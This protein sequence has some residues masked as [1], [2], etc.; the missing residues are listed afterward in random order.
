M[1]IHTFSDDSFFTAASLDILSRYEVDLTIGDDFEEYRELLAE[2]RPDHILGAPFDPTLHDLNEKNAFWIVGR[3]A[4]GTM[5]HAQAMRLL[6]TGTSS[7][8]EFFRYNFRKFPPPGVDIDYQRSRY[9]AGPG[10][11]RMTGRVCY[12]GEVWMGGEP[13]QYRGSG[14]SSL[15]GRFAFLTA[16]Q[17]LS[18]D[19]IMGF[20]LKPVAFK[21]FVERQGY[22]HAEPGALRWYKQGAAD[23]M[24]TFMVY[25]SNED[26]RFVLDMPLQELV[27][28][29]A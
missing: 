10:A 5:M 2:G 13:G 4:D 1:T 6:D 18:P 20:I 27:S 11:Q 21:G 22:M 7:V 26:A 25:M 14:L 3:S 24:E 16:L 29:A 17:R 15:L 12:H 9:R 19:Y 8:G 28:L 23:P